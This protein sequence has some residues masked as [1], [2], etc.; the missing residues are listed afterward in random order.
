MDMT[1]NRRA[2]MTGAVAC[3]G[4]LGAGACTAV[5]PVPSIEVAEDGTFELPAELSKPGGQVKARL[6]LSRERVLIWRTSRGFGACSIVCSHRGSEVHFNEAEGTVD[7]PSHGSRFA[8]DGKVVQGP[9][10]KPLVPYSVTIE[11]NR[12]KILPA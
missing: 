9:A 10:V 7:C 2:F 8:P 5:N 4:T 12:L 6:P 11:G 3:A 1:L